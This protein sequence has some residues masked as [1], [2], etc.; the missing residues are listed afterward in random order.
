MTLSEIKRECLKDGE[1]FRIFGKKKAYAVSTF[2]VAT[3]SMYE[4]I[5]SFKRFLSQDVNNYDRAYVSKLTNYISGVKE[6]AMV[7]RKHKLFHAYKVPM[8]DS[9]MTQFLDESV[10]YLE[11]VIELLTKDCELDIRKGIKNIIDTTIEELY[12]EE[13]D[14]NDNENG[15][16]PFRFKAVPAGDDL[17]NAIAEYTA[18]HHRC[19]IKRLTVITTTAMLEDVVISDI[20]EIMTGVDLWK[21]YKKAK[22]QNNTISRISSINFL[23]KESLEKVVEEYARFK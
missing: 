1:K 6:L 23:D 5:Q 13:D 11:S 10:K 17:Q 9:A 8:F 7:Y 22:K 16:T 4:A 20:T 14:E 3:I 21:S 18:L 2:K 15:N 19:Y 12:E